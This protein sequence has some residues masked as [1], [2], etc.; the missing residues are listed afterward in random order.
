MI[1]DNSTP[2]WSNILFLCLSPLLVLLLAP[3]F[4]WNYGIESSTI[5]VSIGLWFFAGMGI[6]VGYHR[7]FAHRSFAANRITQSFFLLGGAL[8]LQNSAIVWSSDHRK[9]HRN[10]DDKDNDPYAITN[11][12]LWAHIVWIFFEKEEDNK[13]GNVSDLWKNPLVAWQHKYYYAIGLGGNIVLPVF[14]G[15]L[16]GN[17]AEML[18]F[19]GLTRIVALHHFTFCIN[20]LAHV[21]GTQP[22][23]TANSSKDNWF[24][25][26]LTFGEGYHNYHHS[27]ES[28]Y[29]NGPLWYNYDPSKWLIWSLSTIKF[30]HSLKRIP[31]ERILRQQY[32][33]QQHLIANIMT[34]CFDSIDEQRQELVLYLHAQLEETAHNLEDKLQHLRD[35]HVKWKQAHREKINTEKWKR[36]LK[37]RQRSAKE[38]FREWEYCVQSYVNELKDTK[39]LS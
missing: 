39:A 18:L 37:E 16:F 21:W 36:Q 38:A 11:G 1:P 4:I 9:H 8:A 26:L 34:D 29:R 2:I 35:T 30:T 25:S 17:I 20:S 13:L 24:I 19:A 32:K 27:F 12:F 14:F 7:L 6:T 28:D 15:L 3:W 10:I 22:W 31:M 23:S 33:E 5:I